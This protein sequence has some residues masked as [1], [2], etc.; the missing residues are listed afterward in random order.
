MIATRLKTEY[1]GNPLGI[2]MVRPRLQWN[3]DGGITQTAY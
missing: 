3:C 1:L 2:D